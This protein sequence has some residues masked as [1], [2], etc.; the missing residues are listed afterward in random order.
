MPV[1]AA[2][3][4]GAALIPVGPAR[5]VPIIVP[6]GAAS[7]T[8]ILAPHKGICVKVIVAVPSGPLSPGWPPV[9]PARIIVPCVTALPRTARPPLV[10]RMAIAPRAR[11]PQFVAN[12]DQ[13]GIFEVIR[14]GE[15]TDI[16]AV[17]PRD[18]VERVAGSDSVGRCW[19]CPAL[20]GAAA[21][22]VPSE[23][24]VPVVIVS[25]VAE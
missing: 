12:P 15:R 6:V 25:A 16:H 8:P 17:P 10:A 22:T 3:V 14:P 23:A 18:A 1:R 7:A 24:P 5:A 13:A 19:L 21:V 20:H 4:G 11:Y 9:P 2:A